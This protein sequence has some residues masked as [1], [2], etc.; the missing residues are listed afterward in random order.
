M[1]DA[2]RPHGQPINVWVATG[3][4]GQP[5]V[6]FDPIPEAKIIRVLM[7]TRYK[8]LLEMYSSVSTEIRRAADSRSTPDGVTKLRAMVRARGQ[9]ARGPVVIKPQPKL[10]PRRPVVAEYPEESGRSVRAIST[11]VESSKRRH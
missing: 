7:P 11:G 10:E 2:P 1:P 6:S 8:S 3:Q 4:D 5:V 9:F